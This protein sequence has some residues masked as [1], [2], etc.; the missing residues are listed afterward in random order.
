MAKRNVA[1]LHASLTANTLPYEQGMR[2]ARE[3]TQLTMT[4]IQ[5]SMGTMAARGAKFGLGF[6]GV[7]SA[8]KGIQAEFRS[9]LQNIDNIQGL[10]PAAVASVK[11]FE[12]NI[13]SAKQTLDQFVAHNI[14][15]A[16]TAMEALRFQMDSVRFGSDEARKMQE[17]R[18]EEARAAAMNTPDEI[19]RHAEA[20]KALAEARAELAQVGEKDSVRISRLRQEADELEAGVAGL[21][22][23][24]ADS[25]KAQT[26]AVR[27]RIAAEEAYVRLKEQEAEA[28]TKAGQALRVYS[29]VA[30]TGRESVEALRNQ[31]GRLQVEL[32]QLGGDSPEA[33]EQRTK[34]LEELTRAAEGLQKA[35]E[36]VSEASKEL[37]LTFT[38]AMEDAIVSGEELS[39]VLQGLWKDI[40]RILVRQWITQPITGAVTGFISGL[41]PMLGFAD[42]GSPPVGVPSIVGERGPELF[43][44][45]TAGTIIPNHALGGGNQVINVHQS[46]N[47][48]SGV[49]AQ[50]LI[51]I[52][53]MQKRDIIATLADAKRRRTGTAAAYA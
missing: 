15:N 37:G 16:V 39:D 53:Q 13:A 3:A 4:Q 7:E 47:I 31:V 34:K 30:L 50:Q 25:I 45:Q 32:Q 33:L 9:V 26:E 6:F 10:D 8:V 24:D 52:L 29:G 38:S 36:R 46:Y 21:P 22:G 19:K 2:R 23:G 12:G 5:R 48:G 43:V 17:A 11:Q 35:E 40:M 41:G 27:K 49:T 28:Q 44:P 14:S 18:R 1:D 42:G 20:T 51:P